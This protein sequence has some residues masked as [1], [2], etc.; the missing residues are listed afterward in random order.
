M[1]A[2]YKKA[3]EEALQRVPARNGIVRLQD[4]WLETAL[5]KDL[6]VELLREDEII[7]PPHVKRVELR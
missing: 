5:P 6:I 3:V 1:R 7:F 4:L 2:C